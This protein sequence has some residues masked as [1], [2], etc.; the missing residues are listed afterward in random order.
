MVTV[1]T[2]PSE[3]WNEM[4]LISI[5]PIVA[6]AASAKNVHFGALTETVD[7]DIGDKDF[8]QIVLVNGGRL[9]KVTPEAQTTI[10]FE[11]YPLYA[12]EEGLISGA[13]TAGQGFFDLLHAEDTGEPLSISNTRARTKC[14]VALLWTDSLTATDATIN[15]VCPTNK[16]KRFV[17]ADG[18]FI[19]VKPSFTDGLLKYTVKYKANPFASDGSSRIAFQSVGST[20]VTANLGTL[21]SYTTTQWLA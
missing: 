6:T 3:A 13:G 8:D 20:T 9:P 4:C 19:S 2:G 5:S 7:I 17:F 14:R 11:A 16:A 10:T 15:Y 21:V 12:G 18:Y 1:P